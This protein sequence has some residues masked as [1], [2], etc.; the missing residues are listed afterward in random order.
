MVGGVVVV[1]GVV[2][3]TLESPVYVWRGLL[4]GF[5]GGG[6][7]I[8][9]NMNQPPPPP[10]PPP[11]SKKRTLLPEKIGCFGICLLAHIESL[12]QPPGLK[13]IARGG[14]L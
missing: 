11:T 6:V 4:L 12:W 13:K 5:E 10:P 9:N 7:P 2:V 8:A 3:E 1:L 14:Y